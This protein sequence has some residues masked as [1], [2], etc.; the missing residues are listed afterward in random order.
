M[1]FLEQSNQSLLGI[2]EYYLMGKLDKNEL[3][4][5]LTSF[6]ISHNKEPA[7]KRIYC[8][9]KQQLIEYLHHMGSFMSSYAGLLA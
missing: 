7:V 8:A 2:F 5:D 3:A 6:I 1:I 9:E 4:Q